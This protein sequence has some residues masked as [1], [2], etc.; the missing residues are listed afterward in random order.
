MATEVNFEKIRAIFDYSDYNSVL[1]WWTQP[2][3]TDVPPQIYADFQLTLPVSPSNQYNAWAG[4]GG[5]GGRVS[6]QFTQTVAG[7]NTNGA[8][9][10]IYAACAYIEDGSELF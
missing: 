6:I 4:V 8:K 1:G 10:G 3:V 7:Q 9:Q 5:C 2:S